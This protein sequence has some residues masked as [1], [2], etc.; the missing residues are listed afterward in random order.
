MEYIKP[1]EL[2]AMST[3]ELIEAVAQMLYTRA[4]FAS[5][6]EDDAVTPA[7][8]DQYRV[9]SMTYCAAAEN[10]RAMLRDD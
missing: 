4:E 10:V 1:S 2:R 5:R 3:D 9:T 7:I 6:N 8:K